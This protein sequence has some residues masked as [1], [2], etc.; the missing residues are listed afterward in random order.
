[1]KQYCGAIKYN[2][3]HRGE[4]KISQQDLQLTKQD[5][6]YSVQLQAETAKNLSDAVMWQEHLAK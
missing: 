4:L 1:M 5:L 6:E 2:M 3:K